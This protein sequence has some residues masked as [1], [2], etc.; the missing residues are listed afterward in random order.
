MMDRVAQTT[1]AY[2]REHRGLEPTPND[3]TLHHPT[4]AI[5][6]AAVQAGLHLDACL[7]AVWTAT[8]ETVR[9]VARHRLPMPVVGL[10]YDERVYRRMNLLYG[11][12]PLRVKPLS[13]P[14]EMAEVLDA[15][16]VERGLASPD[17]VI[18][19]VTSTRPQTPGATDTVLVH[20]V[21]G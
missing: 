16:L 4:A 21:R 19:V 10:T 18:V 5:A 6:R 9:W 7:V 8:G 11:V 2:Q 13:H 14:A 20:R 12:I 17:D 15:R 1:E 3:P